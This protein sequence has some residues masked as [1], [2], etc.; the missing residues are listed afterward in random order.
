VVDFDD[1]LQL[2]SEERAV[3]VL[4]RAWKEEP[5]LV[6][7]VIFDDLLAVIQRLFDLDKLDNGMEVWAT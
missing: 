1:K 4:N 2:T 7:Q 3:T 6:L 5:E